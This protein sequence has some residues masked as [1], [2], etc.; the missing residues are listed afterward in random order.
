MYSVKYKKERKEKHKKEAWEYN[1]RSNIII[2]ITISSCLGWICSV[3]FYYYSL[4]MDANFFSFAINFIL[5]II[6][7]V[8]EIFPMD[9]KKKS[10]IILGIWL[11]VAQKKRRENNKDWTEILC[12]QMEFY[13]IFMNINHKSFP[14][15]PGKCSMLNY[16]IDIFGEPKKK[17]F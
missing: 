6:H 5:F 16:Y 3:C 10:Y 14:Y 4:W 11:C 15:Q 9:I 1:T 2:Y 7:F 13:F 8:V 17:H 12:I